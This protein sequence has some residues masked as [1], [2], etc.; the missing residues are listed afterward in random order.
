MNK[1]ISLI[2]LTFTVLAFA[3]ADFGMKLRM[4]SEIHNLESTYYPLYYRKADLRIRPSIGYTINDYLSVKSVFEIGDIQIGVGEKDN[5]DVGGSFGTDGINLETK[6]AYLE[7]KTT[8]NHLFRIGLQP[9][10]DAHSIIIDTDLAGALWKGKFNKYTVDLGWFAALDEDEK[11]IINDTYSFGTSVMLLDMGY[12]IN[13]NISIGLNNIFVLKREQY[14]DYEGVNEDIYS[15]YFAPR[16][17][18]EYNKFSVDAQFVANNNGRDYDNV[19]NNPD[20]LDGPRIPNA[21]RERTGLALSIKSNVRMDSKTSLR[22]NFLFRGCEEK[23]ENYESFHSFYDTGLEILN[24]NP[25]GI[26]MHNP[27][28]IFQVSSRDQYGNEIYQKLGVVIASVFVDW[29]FR[30]NIIFTGGMGFAVNDQDYGKKLNYLSPEELAVNKDMFIGWETDIKANIKLYDKLSI[31]PYLA[32]FVPTYNFVY[33]N[34]QN[35]EENTEPDGT[36]STDNQIKVGTTVKY[37]F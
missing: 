24:E 1:I 26:A 4:R 25:N 17:S 22:V 20:F 32:Y 14:L 3:Q 34:P 19:G 16:I 12:T 31:I 23:W 2:V 15:I 27:M 5:K 9:Y 33:N 7:V 6:N 13:K 29:K 11:Y 37:S 18:A 21:G 8:K 30:E 35:L 28:E 36:P 10:K